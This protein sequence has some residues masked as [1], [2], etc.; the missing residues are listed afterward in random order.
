[1]LLVAGV[2]LAVRRP[3]ALSLFDGSNFVTS[4]YTNEELKEV[5][6][7]LRPQ[8]V[9]IDA[10]LTATVGAWRKVDLKAKRF[11][12]KPLPPG[13]RGMRKLTEAGT[14][15]REELESAGLRTLET[16]PSAVRRSYPSV[17]EG[18]LRDAELC[19]LVAYL[20][21]LGKCFIIEEDDG[22]IAVPYEALLGRELL[23]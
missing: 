4:Y 11:G 19:A 22:R 13:W 2:D 8:L 23:P 15:L 7:A 10:P 1:M 17:S 18:D 6:K 21:F 16:L 9:A 5:L 20:C 14:A 3:S 12:L